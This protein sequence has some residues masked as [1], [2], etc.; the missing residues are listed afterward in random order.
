MIIIIL[1]PIGF[2]KTEKLSIIIHICSLSLALQTVPRHK[3]RN[4]LTSIQAK[5]I[6]N[7]QQ[8][9]MTVVMKDKPHPGIPEIANNNYELLS[10]TNANFSSFRI[11]GTA[12]TYKLC[13]RLEVL[14]EARDSRNQIKTRGGDFMLAWLEDVARKASVAADEITDHNNGTYTAK[15]TLHWTGQTQIAVLLIHASETVDSLKKERELHPVRFTYKGMFKNGTRVLVS[16]CN[17]SPDM[18]LL[19]EEKTAVSNGFCNFTDKS[20]GFPWYCLKPA[21]ASC[22]SYYLHSAALERTNEFFR[23]LKTPNERRL[24][25]RK[26]VNGNIIL[27]IL[28][29]VLHVSQ[30]QIIAFLFKTL[31]ANKKQKRAYLAF[32]YRKDHSNRL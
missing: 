10:A 5:Q 32:I 9:H 18:Y 17:I 28:Q 21:T 16:P 4:W 12:H 25:K 24:Y 26:Y 13:G 30:K 6:A 8:R 3:H 15:F 22:D 11:L 2:A 7:A 31:Y 14:I 19:P 23:T 20:T 27:L 29:G 1:S